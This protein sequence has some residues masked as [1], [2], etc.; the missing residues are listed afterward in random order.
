MVEQGS[1]EVKVKKQSV[2]PVKARLGDTGEIQRG[3]LPLQGE[4]S[5]G[6]SSIKVEASQN[7][8]GQLKELF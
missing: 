7:Y 1:S 8:V 4:N 6:Q 3:Y 5:C 2:W